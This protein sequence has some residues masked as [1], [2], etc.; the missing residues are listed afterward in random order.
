M[1][2]TRLAVGLAVLG[3]LALAAPGRGAAAD[4]QVTVAQVRLGETL[5][6]PAV[7]SDDLKGR[8]VLLEF[9]GIS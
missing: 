3:G 4:E 6:G 8:V 5:H 7:K 9:W 2:R 1:D